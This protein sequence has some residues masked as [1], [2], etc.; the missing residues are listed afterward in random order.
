MSLPM[1]TVIE[2]VKECAREDGDALLME[3]CFDVDKAWSY[4]EKTLEKMET[5]SKVKV[6][7]KRRTV[8][9]T[10]NANRARR[11]RVVVWRDCD[12]SEFYRSLYGAEA[13][14]LDYYCYATILELRGQFDA[15]NRVRLGVVDTEEDAG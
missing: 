5:T 2:K 4:L 9:S 8:G 11:E 6:G 13:A 14:L 1:S 12:E 10:F 15:V 7:G 3:A